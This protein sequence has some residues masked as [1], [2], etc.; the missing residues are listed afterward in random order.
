MF[1]VAS[2]K[3]ILRISAFIILA[4]L[5]SIHPLQIITEAL[6]PAFNS[7]EKIPVIK[8]SR[9]YLPANYTH[10]M[11]LVFRFKDLPKNQWRETGIATTYLRGNLVR[12]Y[13]YNSYNHKLVIADLD[14]VTLEKNIRYIILQYFD[15]KYGEPMIGVNGE[16]HPVLNYFS[17][18]H[19]EIL[20]SGDTSK[21]TVLVAYQSAHL[22]RVVEAYQNSHRLFIRDTGPLVITVLDENKAETYLLDLGARDSRIWTG[23][24]VIN[25]FT[26]GGRASLHTNIKLMENKLLVS[27]STLER[28]GMP[29]SGGWFDY[30]N[31]EFI[32]PS[33]R[34]LI[35]RPG[36]ILASINLTSMTAINATYVYAVGYN[37]TAK[38]KPTSDG[39]FLV[40]LAAKRSVLLAKIDSH[41]KIEWTVRLNLADILVPLKGGIP[42]SYQAA[43]RLAET[44]NGYA[45]LLPLK[46]KPLLVFLGKGGKLRWTAYLNSSKIGRF[47]NAHLAASGDVIYVTWHAI[48]PSGSSLGMVWITMIT[49]NGTVI[50]SYRN[51]VRAD[52][53]EDLFAEVHGELGRGKTILCRPEGYRARRIQGYMDVAYLLED[54]ETMEL[55]AA[56]PFRGGLRTND[57]DLAEGMG[58]NVSRTGA[59]WVNAIY[60]KTNVSVE[61]YSSVV[62]ARTG[63]TF[64]VGGIELHIT[65]L[66]TVLEDTNMVDFIPSF[67]YPI[68]ILPDEVDFGQVHVG[69]EKAVDIEMIW[70]TQI[71]D[72]AEAVAYHNPATENRA[73]H[74]EQPL[75]EAV[76]GLKNPDIDVGKRVR[77]RIYF[78]PS[79][80]GIA[81]STYGIGQGPRG[82]YTWSPIGFDYPRQTIPLRGMGVEN[83]VPIKLG[84]FPATIGLSVAAYSLPS[85]I[86]PGSAYRESVYLTN[87]GNGEMVFLEGVMVLPGSSVIKVDGAD[88]VIGLPGEPLD[89]FFVVVVKIKPMETK[90][91]DIYMRLNAGIA[92]HS[93]P[94]YLLANPSF[95]HGA[96]VGEVASLPPANWS[97]ILDSYKDK[98]HLAVDEAIKASKAY[99][100]KQ[101]TA[102]FTTRSV[103]E[104]GTLLNGLRYEN[105]ALYDYIKYLVL[106][107]TIL[108][109][110]WFF[111]DNDTAQ[112][113]PLNNT[114]GTVRIPITRVVVK[115]NTTLEMV[116]T[117]PKSSSS[118]TSVARFS[119][120]SIPI[121]QGSWNP[122]FM[123]YVREFFK[124][125][126]FSE[127]AIQGLIGLKKGVI[128]TI[129]LGLK[130]EEAENEYQAAGKII[131]IVATNLEM[132]VAEPLVSGGIERLGTFVFSKM[133]GVLRNIAA[134]SSRLA[135]L[136]KM[137][138][139]FKTL[140]GLER[141]V[142]TEQGE[143]WGTLI[144]WSFNERFAEQGWYLG[145][146]YVRSQVTEIGGKLIAKTFLHLYPRAG[147]I[148]V[149]F[150][151]KYWDI[152]VRT[153][154]QMGT[155][156]RMT[157]ML[158]KEG[159]F[160][161]LGKE[162]MKAIMDPKMWAL[163]GLAFTPTFW[164]WLWMSGLAG[165]LGKVSFSADPNYADLTPS[166]YMSNTDSDIYATIHFENLANAT[167]PAYNITVEIHIGG[168]VDPGSLEIWDT[169]HPESFDNYNVSATSEGLMVRIRF[170]N[171]TLPPNKEPPEGEGWVTI[172]FRLKDNAKPGSE[173]S[174]YGDVYFDYNPPVR[175][176]TA[177][178]IYDPDPPQISIATDSSP[179]KLILSTICT[180]PISGC[181]TSIITVTDMQGNIYG[182]FILEPGA[183]QELNLAPGIYTVST[184]AWDNA[185]N[186][187]EFS[188]N[189]TVPGKPLET[190][191]TQTTNNSTTSNT[192]KHTSGGIP[193]WI[194]LIVILILAVATL[195]A[196]TKLRNP[197]RRNSKL[198]STVTGDRSFSVF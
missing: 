166:P 182:P 177:N 44:E 133:G 181:N 62:L 160:G 180:D 101:L 123:W 1:L 163:G 164:T 143:A 95:R 9:D 157:L 197:N 89:P 15:T 58:W 192:T 162:M 111:R 43:F 98:P 2:P 132:I 191:T 144:K 5:I 25:R 135:F 41:F 45:V 178:T 189:I 107:G 87:V 128:E 175:T 7:A 185:G 198:P 150:M 193:A 141:I 30:V 42:S 120:P 68:A 46:G 114:N 40:L 56:S 127:T 4:L 59:P 57:E 169:S 146:G 151:G 113:Y 158:H 138:G 155:L 3:Y 11:N 156:G 10:A 55:G 22:T 67:Y 79:K 117:E 119:A 173:V 88:M 92:D 82:I 168:P 100:N 80:P 61:P 34:T 47:I 115:N 102:F 16:K 86:L 35:S 65:K 63:G 49:T 8:P 165:E 24:G 149:Y 194:Y 137:E 6:G 184:T 52:A 176:N 23:N 159:F 60:N 187:A 121:S 126:E 167:A 72:T 145:I 124:P 188:E 152:P 196:G 170:T 78:K 71:P 93:N 74:A 195:V 21:G 112:I 19:S 190:T 33:N 179:G 118:T 104:A 147:K 28:P 81:T 99:I 140:A 84:A 171:I 29:A 50:G 130:H 183:S 14:L 106:T 186:T 31:T 90:R 26:P 125:K 85:H 129:S 109:D 38:A 153:L 12:A 172:K 64:E 96:L 83:G 108:N 51:N 122:G 91:I 97:E 37:V 48:P 18:S 32:R 54:Y 161:P 13:A 134:S 70:L 53:Y 116:S 131:G 20:G 77:V 139:P 66:I 36:A 103:D 136:Y 94:L 76:G 75:W 17:G 69:E 174:I 73:F 27:Q 105:P 142:M 148:A 110:D 154:F 39:G